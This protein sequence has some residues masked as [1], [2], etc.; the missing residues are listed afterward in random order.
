MAASL[1]DPKFG[2]EGDEQPKCE[3]QSS[4][5]KYRAQMLSQA[6][7]SKNKRN[8]QVQYCTY[9]EEARRAAWSGHEHPGETGRERESAVGERGKGR[10]RQRLEIA[11]RR[12]KTQEKAAFNVQ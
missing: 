8:A 12:E 1:P 6:E 10:E 5:D 2:R 11:T 9:L 4:T 7:E 3:L